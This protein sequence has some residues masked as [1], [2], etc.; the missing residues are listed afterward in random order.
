MGRLEKFV[1]TKV[2]KFEFE[3]EIYTIR[4][5]KVKDADLISKIQGSKDDTL[6]MINLNVE[7]LSRLITDEDVTKEA[8][9]EM[10]SEVFGEFSNKAMETL[11]VQTNKQK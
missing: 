3:G 7:L 5:I 1:N 9:L 10:D 8:L 4:P 6:E 2:K 11:G